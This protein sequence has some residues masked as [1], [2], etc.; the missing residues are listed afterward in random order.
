M[1][2]LKY[3]LVA[4]FMAA[5]FLTAAFG[6]AS[7]P[8]TTYGKWWNSMTTSEKVVLVSGVR[9]GVIV[10]FTLAAGIENGVM[11]KLLSDVDTILASISMETTI[12]Y[13]DKFYSQS[14]ADTVPFF[15]AFCQMITDFVSMMGSQSKTPEVALNG[16]EI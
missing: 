8:E 14:F 9:H 13:M 4:V 10:A 7:I 1:K 3:V 11:M 6:H 16:S 2:T 12:V 5:F 15:Q